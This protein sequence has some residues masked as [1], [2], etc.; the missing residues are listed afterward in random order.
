M[1]LMN[2]NCI[3]NACV[4]VPYYVCIDAVN[5]IDFLFAPTFYKY[6]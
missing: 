5:V 1:W 6:S 3:L 4:A 2:L